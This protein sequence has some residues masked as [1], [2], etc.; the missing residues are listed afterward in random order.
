[1]KQYLSHLL[2]SLILTAFSFFVPS[3]FAQNPTFTANDTTLCG[4]GSVTFT[5]VANNVSTYSWDFGNMQNGGNFVSITQAYSVT[6]NYTVTLYLTYT[7]GQ[8][9]TVVRTNYISVFTPPT[10]NFT[11]SP[12]QLCLGQTVQFTHS[13]VAGSAPITTYTWDFGDGFGSSQAN[14]AHVYNLAS[15]FPVVLIVTDANGCTDNV[16]QSAYVTVTQAPSA[17]FT[18]NPS[19]S[20]NLNTPINFVWS[21]G[22]G[23]THAW[24]FGA[25]QGTSTAA[26]PTYTYT[27]NGVY[28]VTHTVT[29]ASGCTTSYTMNNAVQVGQ[30]PPTITNNSVQFC[31]GQPISVTWQQVALNTISWN[32]GGGSPAT[33]SA[34]SPTFT[35]ATPGTY[36]ITATMTDTQTGCASNATLTVNVQN[37]PVVSFASTT[38]L[39]CEAPHLVSFTSNAPGAVSYSWNFGD[40]GTSIS[41]NPTH[42]YTATGT[43]TVSL[44]VTNSSGCSATATMPSFVQ[45]VRPVAQFVALPNPQGCVPYTVN[46]QDQSTSGSPIISWEWDFGT[47]PASTSNLQNPTFTYT[48]TGNFTVILIITNADGCKDTLIRTNYVK[49]GTP[50]VVNFSATPTDTCGTYPITFTS[51]SVPLG[52]SSWQFGQGQGTGSGTIATHTYTDTGYF[53]VTLI[54]NNQGCRDTLILPNYIHIDGPIVTFSITPVQ[55]CSVPATVTITNASIAAD[56]Y[57]WDFND[58]TFDITQNPPPHTYTTP[59]TYTISLT[60]GNVSTG[61]SDVYTQTFTIQLP[62][63]V[64]AANIVQSCA[65]D[66]VFFFNLSA[67]TASCVWNFGDSTGSTSF[68]PVHTYNLP[69]VYTVILTTVNTIG[70]QM[71]DTI[72]NYIN[73]NGLDVNFI[74]DTDSGCS[75]LTVQFTDQTNQTVPITQWDW[76]FG[77]GTSNLQN[78]TNIYGFAGSYDVTLSVT[79]ANGCVSTHT[80]TGFVTVFDPQ[81][82]FSAT[83]PVNCI[84]NPVIFSA[85][86]TGANPAS[87]YYSWTYGDGATS[88]ISTP[89][90]THIYNTNGSYTVSLTITDPNGCTD[91]YTLNNYITIGTLIVDFTTPG[92]VTAACPPFLASYSPVP[93]PPFSPL[94]LSYSW[95][96]GDG[97]ASIL[98]NPTHYYVLPGDYTVGMIITDVSGCTASVIKNNLIHIDGPLATYIISPHSVCPGFPVTF[99]ATGTNVVQYNWNFGDAGVS[100]QN[101]TQ[102]IYAQPASTTPA[103]YIPTLTVVDGSGCSVLMPQTDTL[104]VHIPPTAAFGVDSTFACVPAN[105]VFTDSSTFSD[106]TLAAWDWAYGDGNTGT[107]NPSPHTYNTPGYIDVTM[108]VTDE[109]GCKDTL[110]HNDLLYLIPNVQPYKPVIYA[111]SVIKNDSVELTFSAYKDVVGDF[112]EYRLFRSV[113]ASAPILVATV[114]DIQDTVIQDFAPA[115]NT[116]VYCYFLNY[117]NHCGNPS[118]SSAH[119]CTIDLQMSSLIDTIQLD[120]TNYTGWTPQKYYI[121]RN[122]SYGSGTLIDSVAG[123]QHI[124]KD[125]RVDC[126]TYYSYRVQAKETGTSWRVFSDTAG[127]MS[128]HFTSLNPVETTLATVEENKKVKLTWKIPNSV[129]KKYV[130]QIEKRDLSVANSNFAQL[131]AFPIP[132]PPNYTDLSANVKHNYEYRTFVL[133]S[134]GDKT[135]IG[136][137]ATNIVAKA[138]R[139]GDQILI[140]WSPYRDWV[141]GVDFYRIELKNT[142]SNPVSYLQVADIPGSDTFFYEIRKPVVQEDNCYTVRAYKKYENQTS[143]LSNE[144]CTGL[145]AQVTIPN[146]FTPNADNI[147]DVF[148]LQ[149][150]FIMD[151]KLNIYDRWGGQI[152]ESNNI[153]NSW[154]GQKNGQPAP[155]GTYMYK[156]VVTG[157][158]GNK[159]F[160]N[161]TVILIR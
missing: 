140:A 6:G 94:N 151:Y 61:C 69:G 45:I 27:A 137:V 104:V 115:A 107:G 117:V 120:W 121:Y 158:S 91:T 144:A 21:G 8:H 62:D 87:L 128:L 39:A 90:P 82:T 75:P 50:P 160:R 17:V 122:V 155:E 133:D 9:D 84:G 59:G 14:P 97:G 11:G 150:V 98:N 159:Q 23:Y 67:N 35:Y 7:N 55:S 37:S 48:N 71:S 70:C 134:C 4:S 41:A 148:A 5:A 49:V 26:S 129:T 34:I 111:A 89:T 74:V 131:A 12:L 1:M 53:D 138:T 85:N 32:S 153:G 132:F 146:V 80:E 119:H 141:D 29:T 81:V 92:G 58:N 22:A 63:A 101:P 127:V 79:D 15:V 76:N 47:V 108:I 112:G 60:A 20:C 64:F 19:I 130:L 116:Q 103:T 65:P 78:P 24:T 136:N 25:G 96:F 139:E 88:G 161:G 73:M 52:Q 30:T 46:F 143:S 3:V 44:T 118:D 68:N 16:I 125:F 142:Q 99:T 33:S 105:V 18:V 102:H 106:G 113:G 56:Y 40:G 124:Y 114:T 36:T 109:F 156:L 93:S 66:S 31:T 110:T 149:G 54:V 42:N 147:N 83:Y 57:S 86:V 100:Q 95:T 152:F 77:N 13:S 2:V 43:F 51:T 135:P 10:A 38:N 154:D 157:Y 72:V 28:T 126:N 145:G 123:N